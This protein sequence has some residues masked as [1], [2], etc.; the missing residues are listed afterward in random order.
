MTLARTPVQLLATEPELADLAR[1]ADAGVPLGTL[2]VVPAAAE[3]RF[4]RWNN[5]PERLLEVFSAVDV[6]DPDEDDLEEA[7]PEARELIR[8][9]YLL[10]EF[11]DDF[12]GAI[13]ELHG[14][15]RVRRPGE[16]GVQASGGRPALMALK[17]L[18]QDDW[19][20][21]AVARRLQRTATLAL[22]ARPVLV[23]D[24]SSAPAPDALTQRAR[25]V[26]GAAVE[27]RTTAEGRIVGVRRP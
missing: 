7:V 1:L 22:D 13:A 6:A 16:D 12:Y 4:Y 20:V 11:I 21:E 8:Q 2:I 18:Y 19:T 26:L 5:L 3:E 15:V 14:A 27:L 17:A 10:D 24:G 25:D 9:T 23:H